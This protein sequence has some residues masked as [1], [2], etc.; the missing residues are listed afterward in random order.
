[1]ISD[2]LG[3]PSFS[4]SLCLFCKTIVYRQARSHR[5]GDMGERMSPVRVGRKSSRTVNFYTH[6][7]KARVIVVLTFL[8]SV[9]KCTITWHFHG[10][11]QNFP[12]RTHATFT[13]WCLRRP[14][15]FPQNEIL[16]IDACLAMDA[17]LMTIRQQAASVVLVITNNAGSTERSV[18]WL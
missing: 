5:G 7:Y 3:K 17:L 10:R 4:S 6:V 16:S 18:N 2:N 14:V 15:P 11:I 8:D 9:S 1:M 13:P 12:Q